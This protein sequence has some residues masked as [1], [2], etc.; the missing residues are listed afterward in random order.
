MNAKSAKLDRISILKS[1]KSYIDIALIGRL[2][3]FSHSSYFVFLAAKPPRI[4]G[5]LARLRRLA[6][7]PCVRRIC[8]KQTAPPEGARKFLP[9]QHELLR[10]LSIFL[11]QLDLYENR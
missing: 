6:R 5:P 7:Q 11:W 3:H 1:A 8:I 2:V 4:V 9:D 10:A